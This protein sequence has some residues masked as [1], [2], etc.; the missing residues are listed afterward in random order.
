M[1]AQ[2]DAGTQKRRPQPDSR[3]FARYVSAVRPSF[4]S[5][6][7]LLIAL[8]AACDRSP[9]RDVSS[10][11]S[12]GPVSVGYAGPQALVLRVPRNGGTPVVD[13]YPRVDSA[14]WRSTDPAPI[15]ARVLAFDDENGNVAYVDTKGR[16]VLL[17][18]R[19]GAITVASAKKLRGLTSADGR[20]IYGIGSTG[21][22]VRITAT[23]EWTF[24][25]PQAANAVFPQADG[26]AFIAVGTGA[27]THLIK[28]F[29]PEKK[30]LEDVPFPSATRI[31]RTQL[32][33]VL[34][35]AV[36]SGLSVLRTRTLEWA[37]PIHFDEPISVMAPTPSGDRM[38]VLT[39]SRTR[40]SV[41]DRYR[42]RVSGTFEL[43]GRASDLRVDPFGRYLLARAESGD[44]IWVVAI[45]TQRVIGGIQAA[46]RN[47]LPFVGYDGAVAVASGADVLLYDGETLRVRARIRGGAGDYWYPFMWDGFRPRSASLDEPVRFDS[48]ALD[49]LSRD[50]TALRDS[51][52]SAPVA[53][54]S[55]VAAPAGFTVSFAAFLAEDR[56][57]EL[58]AAIRVGGD[59][60]R[61]VTS[62]R[63]GSTIY[64]VIL[65][66][67]P[68]KEQAESV[69][70][71]SGHSYW[72]YQGT[73]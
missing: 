19:L 42:D 33:D 45:G 61:V 65:G 68:S 71:A 60:A 10:T 28:V 5:I 49:T 23:D 64:R 55:A 56:A 52:A 18:L 70:R 39:D 43:P 67:Y 2:R 3:R 36:D 51:S 57:N 15:P 11:Q 32:G 25:P 73:P 30:V 44:S 63:D 7:L 59:T 66:P 37:A 26:A 54:D 34:Y 16:P 69:G 8:A 4:S 29:P 40:I 53:T 50:T 27:N 24:K 31:A 41:V 22:V 35:L 1:P 20:A 21:D 47:D 58:A 13:A 38:F 48:I 14:V 6:P 72:V 12:G 62:T 46:W 17:E 9:A